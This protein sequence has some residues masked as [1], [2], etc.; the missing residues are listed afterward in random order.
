MKAIDVIIK[1]ILKN[2]DK[3]SSLFTVLSKIV[4]NT[5]KSLKLFRDAKKFFKIKK[6]LLSIL[7]AEKTNCLIEKAIYS[8]NNSLNLLY[9]ITNSSSLVKRRTNLI[10]II[11][12]FMTFFINYNALITFF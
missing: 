4:E 9:L 11:I 12:A 10:R 8:N 5:K 3:S 6:F 1:K 7:K 2:V